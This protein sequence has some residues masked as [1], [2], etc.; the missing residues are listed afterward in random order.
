MEGDFSY[1]SCALIFFFVWIFAVD[2]CYFGREK[3]FNQTKKKNVLKLFCCLQTEI[4]RKFIETLSRGEGER[5]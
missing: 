1:I 3:I 2:V 5:L 4:M